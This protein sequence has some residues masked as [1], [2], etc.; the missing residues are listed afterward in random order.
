M[1]Q[2]GAG[3]A[4]GH[5]PT[6]T[7]VPNQGYLN[8]QRA[9]QGMV[10]AEDAAQ[11]DDQEDEEDYDD[12]LEEDDLDSDA[13]MA[14]NPSDYTKSYN[15]QRRL[16]EAVADPNISKSQYP[17]SNPQP[18]GGDL[19]HPKD[20]QVNLLSKHAAKLKLEDKYSGTYHGK[21]A[22]K[23][24]RATSEQVLDPRTRMILLQM[25]NRNVVSEINGVISTGKEANVYHAL[26]INDDGS[27]IHRAIKVY[28]TSILVFKDR[29]KYVA[30]EFRFRQGYNKSNNRAMVKIWA[31]KE[32][33]N[34]KR[35]HA[36]GIP[37][38]DPLYLR[39]H[40]LAMSFLGDSKGIASP[41]LKDVDF[42]DGDP[43]PRWRGLYIS[44]LGYMRIMYQ[45]CHLV[46]ADLSEYNIL[47]HDHRPH[48]IDVSQSVEHD[49]P[50]SL[51]FLRMDIKNINDFFSR[52]NVFT[53]ADRA[54]YDF[55][56]RSASSSTPN[57][58]ELEELEKEIDNLM[59][60]RKETD[61]EESE[62]DNAVFRN[63]YIPQTLNE[64][65]D[66]ERDIDTLNAT[67]QDTRVYKDLLANKPTQPGHSTSPAA[68]TSP[69]SD[70]DSEGS[71]DAVGAALDGD[72]DSESYEDEEKGPPRGKR[73]VDKEEK[74]AH[75]AAVK[76]EKREKRQTKMPKHLKK[77][78]VKEKSRGKK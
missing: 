13:L 19:A 17:K 52:K 62:V 68:S 42:I 34:L 74:K 9:P 57:S 58:N 2:N 71:D 18:S 56:L 24:E 1:A 70:N 75:K 45:V 65:Y 39:L 40:V 44:I 29:E 12:I 15:R 63:Q 66:A 78:L 10:T 32:M 35:I 16:N 33:R 21:G 6:H 26:S 77:K 67:G 50:R 60:N 3:V 49:H 25:I 30:G 76:E 73:F 38:P 69:A 59:S 72:S 43:L 23:S 11:D 4:D 46:H 36:A 37:S 64:V 48:I 53:L 27:E 31:E 22:D 8:D 55:I 28:K 5:Q 7:Y 54:V 51:D 47:L 41:R 20:D 61:L 14:A